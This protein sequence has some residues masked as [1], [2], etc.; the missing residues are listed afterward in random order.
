MGRRKLYKTAKQIAA[1]KLKWAEKRNAIRRVLYAKD[2]SYR[3]RCQV[4]ARL[5]ARK[6]AV[7][8]QPQYTRYL[9]CEYGIAHIKTIAQSRRLVKNG[10]VSRVQILCLT[11]FEFSKAS[12]LHHVV[13]LHKWQRNG[14]IPRPAVMA[15]VGRTHACVYTIEQAEAMLKVLLG[16][17]SVKSYLSDSDADTIVKLFNVMN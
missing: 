14:K 3:S 8:P 2:D 10:V 17:Y 11:S 12:G 6:D 13:M 7:N 4:A 9:A 5:T 1:Q 16:H 15:V